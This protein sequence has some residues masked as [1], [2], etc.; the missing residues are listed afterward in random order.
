MY[1]HRR[2]IDLHDN[3][4]EMEC[5]VLREFDNGDIAYIQLSLLDQIDL[6]R[7]TKIVFRRNA[8]NYPLWDLMSQTTLGNGENA[9]EYFD[10]MTMVK[11]NNGEHIAPRSGGRGSVG[12]NR[13]AQQKPAPEQPKKRGPGR[14][15]KQK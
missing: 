6:D 14:P 3:G 12:H 7:L 2:F 15:P 13:M 8:H 1:E 5:V 11:T 9:L 4:V 10:Q